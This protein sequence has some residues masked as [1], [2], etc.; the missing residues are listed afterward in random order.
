MNTLPWILIA[1]FVG[2]VV[3]AWLAITTSISLWTS[4]RENFTAKAQ[5]N[6]HTM[7]LFVDAR[8]VF[9]SNVLAIVVVPVAVYLATGRVFYAVV[10]GVV[11]FYMPKLIY[12]YLRY[13]RLAQ[14]EQHLPDALTMIG[15]A[16][17]AG[18]S[19]PMSIEG[20]VRETAG[21]ISQEFSMVLR[22]QRMGV[23]LD[24]AFENLGARVASQDLTL[25]VAAARIARDVGG[26]LSEIFER[27][28]DT[29]R[30]KAAMEGKIKALTSQGKMQ[31]WV[32]GLLPVGII[33]VLYQMEPESMLPL[34]TSI[35]GWAVLTV[36]GVLELMGGL[37]IK[38]IVT[39]DI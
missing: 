14:F 23:S 17:R 32:V 20:M 15:G 8:R 30:Q 37:M 11:V 6:L 3:A 27:L 1:V 35:A 39:I 24:E 9:M 16:M 19:L 38:K 28:A 34:F 22:E 10:L 33:A 2:G 12:R 4:Y 21:P 18:A 7:F 26:N 29:L 5:E 31:G 36:I 25:V 13:R